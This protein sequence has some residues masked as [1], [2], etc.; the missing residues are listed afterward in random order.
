MS[1]HTA[2]T[3]TVRFIAVTNSRIV[4]KIIKKMFSHTGS[5]IIDLIRGRGTSR[6]S[7]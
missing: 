7:Y 3:V 1:K 6:V 5:R 4:Q 2:V